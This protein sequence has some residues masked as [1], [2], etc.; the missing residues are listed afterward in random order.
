[1]NI[2]TGAT[3]GSAGLAPAR[4]ATRVMEPMMKMEFTG[5]MAGM[6]VAM[7]VSRMLRRFAEM[8]DLWP[9]FSTTSLNMMTVGSSD[10]EAGSR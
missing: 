7:A 9:M 5:T 8:P 2:G 3:R 4:P 6:F 10:P 1:M